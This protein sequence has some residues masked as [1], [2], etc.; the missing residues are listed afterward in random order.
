MR[1]ARF[2]AVMLLFAAAAAA[3]AA[4]H[5]Q[6]WPAKPIRFVSAYP[7]GGPTDIL[8][9]LI[10][11]KLQPSLGQS[12][13]VENRAGAGGNV[14]TDYVAKQLGDGYTILMAAS[15]PLAINPTLYKNLPFD[16]E[17]DLVPVILVARVPLL[18]VVHPA[19]PA[20]S[21]R[22]LIELG[23][24]SPDRHAYASAGNG[25]PIHL[26]MELFKSMTGAKFVHVPYKGTGPALNDVIGGQ[27]PMTFEGMLAV[28]P[29]VKSGRLRALAVSSA[30]RWPTVPDVPTVAE[31]GVPGY[32]AYA[33]YG[34]LAS[35]GTPR[36]IVLRLNSEIGRA[37]DSDELATTL[38]DLG[39]A[40]THG[41]PEDF[42]AFIRAEAAKWSKIV[43][44]SGATVD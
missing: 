7:P 3:A 4:A 32:E 33:W 36:E 19:F 29:H 35:K 44:V 18:L 21:V 20:A 26:S 41:S 15:G 30:A 17:K 34:V 24:K 5:A 11:A 39:S 12:V 31:A 14:G 9:R 10:A 43:A 27:V 13:I 37:L 8:A 2:F 42:A 40:R 23:R 25:T 22:E 28:L 16:P 38:K 1:S 6:P